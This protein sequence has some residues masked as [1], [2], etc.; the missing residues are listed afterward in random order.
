MKS[1]P[2][3]QNSSFETFGLAPIE[4]LIAGCNLLI[5]N[6]IGAKGVLTTTEDK[7]IIFDT[8]SIEGIAGKIHE[9]IIDGN[10]DRLRKGLSEKEIRYGRAAGLLLEKI[11]R[12]AKK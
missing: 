10:Y 1:Y 3:I 9:L 12:Y 7:D 5:S 8:D 11:T 2:C 4:A 6:E